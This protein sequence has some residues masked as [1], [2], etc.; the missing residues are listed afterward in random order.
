MRSV[1]MNVNALYL[2]TIDVSAQMVASVD[3]K[4]SFLCLLS[5]IGKHSAKQTR[6]NYEIIVGF[7]YIFTL[8]II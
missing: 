5:L 6:T 7:H 4:A 1:S 2:V 3:H 8:E